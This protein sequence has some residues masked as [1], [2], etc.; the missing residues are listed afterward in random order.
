MKFKKLSDKN[1]TE[2][3]EICQPN[4][5]YLPEM[6]F[7]RLSL[8]FSILFL[9]LKIT[10]TTIT[11]ARYIVGLVGIV[12]I[13][14]GGYEYTVIGLI[15]FHFSILLDYVD[16]E[17]F[18]YQTWKTGKKDS[19]LKGSFLDKVFDHSYRPLLLI[20]AGIGA[21]NQFGN[22][23]FIYLGIAGAIFVSFDQMMKLK[24]LEVLVYKQQL[25]YLK[26]EK[27]KLE[28]ESGK[29]DI[30]YELF[31]INNPLTLYF[32]FGIFG[33]L[34]VFLLIYVPLLF[35]LVMKTFYTQYRSIKNMDKEILKEMYKN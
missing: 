12:F 27:K 23:W 11:F 6:M 16:G 2:L 13:G 3:R 31:R 21:F 35:L 18:R 33:Y 5:G 26:E 32:W 15:I 4:K 20:A 29:L 34:Y 9:Y 1:V 30:F 24:V 28:S 8:F 17:M 7:R 25:H 22:I 14:L 10:P 19:I